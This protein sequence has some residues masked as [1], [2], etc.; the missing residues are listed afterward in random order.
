MMEDDLQQKQALELKL[1]TVNKSYTEITLMGLDNKIIKK[2][3][4]QVFM[5]RETPFFFQ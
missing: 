3:S 5:I 4:K 1:K 2:N